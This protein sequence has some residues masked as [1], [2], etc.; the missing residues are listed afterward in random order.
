MG[1]KS[2][3]LTVAACWT[4]SVESYFRFAAQNATVYLFLSL[5]S[6]HKDAACVAGVGKELLVVKH[7]DALIM[8]IAENPFY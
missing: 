4:M 7:C 6:Y 3:L 2:V 8:S 1:Q 5:R